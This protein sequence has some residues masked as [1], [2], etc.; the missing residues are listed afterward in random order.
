MLIV[1]IRS[2]D[3][4]L[5][6]V[7]KDGETPDPTPRFSFISYD[8]MHKVLAPNR[9]G[10]IRSM[11]GQGPLSIREIARR[12]GRGFKGVHTDVTALVRSGLVAKTADGQVIFPYLKIRFDFEIGANDQSA[13]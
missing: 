13:A 1:D 10:I 11:T 4:L 6:D 5:S 2:W 3:E 9:I 8:L 12:V 7:E